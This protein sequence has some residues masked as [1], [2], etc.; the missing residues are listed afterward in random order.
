MAGLLARGQSAKKSGQPEETANIRARS[1]AWLT[2]N[3]GHCD[4]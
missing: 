1:M 4:R 2:P 3:A